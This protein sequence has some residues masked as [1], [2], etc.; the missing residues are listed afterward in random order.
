MGFPQDMGIWRCADCNDK[1]EE[2]YYIGEDMVCKECFDLIKKDKCAEYRMVRV[3]IK[4]LMGDLERTMDDDECG[5]APTTA[6]Q[7]LSDALSDL[8]K[9]IE[10]LED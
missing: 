2:P 5:H 4:D 3:K 9:T 6:Y 8:D 10:N 7:R 1:V